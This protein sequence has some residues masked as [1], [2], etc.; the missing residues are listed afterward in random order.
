[1]WAWMGAL[2]VTPEA[3]LVS[4]A[5]GVYRFD[6][7][8]LLPGFYDLFLRTKGYV[9]EMTRYSKGVWSSRLRLY[10]DSFL[11]LSIPVPPISEQRAIVTR[12]KTVEFTRRMQA[13]NEKLHGYRQALITAAV[14]GKIDVSK[15]AA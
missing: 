15:A 2:G 7:S 14:T 10:P 1:M 9:A 8:Q 11:A 6:Q 4:P 3:G 5:Y 12:L 13:A